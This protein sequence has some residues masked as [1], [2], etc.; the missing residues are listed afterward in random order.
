MKTHR[1]LTIHLTLQSSTV[2]HYHYEQR[3]LIIPFRRVKV[4]LKA[5]II[6]IIASAVSILGGIAREPACKK[7]GE[8][9]LLE[10]EL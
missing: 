2:S 4:L 10:E 1:C 3:I 8:R 6:I 5:R 7:K 9:C